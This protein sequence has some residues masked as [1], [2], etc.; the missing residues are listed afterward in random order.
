MRRMQEL[1]QEKRE[2]LERVRQEFEGED[3][4]KVEDDFGPEL[5][6]YKAEIKRQLASGAVLDLR[7]VNMHIGI[8]KEASFSG[9][10]RQDREAAGG[11]RGQHGGADGGD[12]SGLRPARRR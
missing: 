10:C 6:R 4:E 1:G 3:D 2:E 12:C 8:D 9:T 7:S 5:A 11:L